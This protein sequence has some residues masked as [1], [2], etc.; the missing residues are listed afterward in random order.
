MPETT[1]KSALGLAT[2]FGLARWQAGSQ[3]YWLT[4]A[5]D[6]GQ[7]V[8][9]DN[10]RFTKQ[11]VTAMAIIIFWIMAMQR[12]ASFSAE[13][14]LPQHIP[15]IVPAQIFINTDHRRTKFSSERNVLAS[16]SEQRC[17]CLNTKQIKTEPESVTRR[18]RRGWLSFQEA[19]V[20][21]CTRQ[22][23]PSSL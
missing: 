16:Q 12:S 1:S 14:S 3:G 18:F 2:A 7:N 19:A 20:F 10:L 13:C 9:R 21:R 5:L 6:T 15:T 23:R 22:G 4:S 17:G 8:K 11:T